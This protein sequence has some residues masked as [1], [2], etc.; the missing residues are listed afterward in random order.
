MARIEG[1]RVKN[2]K[3]LK[4]VILGRLWN[5]WDRAPL[6]KAPPIINHGLTTT[7]YAVYYTAT[8]STGP[9]YRRPRAS[10]TVYAKSDLGRMARFRRT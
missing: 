4:D 10:A 1:F 5:Q 3:V 7:R 2:F 8:A 9:V 6:R